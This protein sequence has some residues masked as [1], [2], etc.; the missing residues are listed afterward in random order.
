[1]N[2]IIRDKIEA[3][4]KKAGFFKL[5]NRD[6]WAAGKVPHQRICDLSVEPIW[7]GISTGTERQEAEECGIVAVQDIKSDVLN[8]FNSSDIKKPAER[9]ISPSDHPEGEPPMEPKS[10]TAAVPPDSA[11][12]SHIFICYACQTGISVEQRSTSF[13]E[14]GRA[15]CEKCI[16]AL[17]EK[18]KLKE[19]PEQEKKAGWETKAKGELKKE[20]KK[21]MVKDDPKPPLS[22]KELS[23]KLEAEEQKKE[24][25]KTQFKVGTCEAVAKQYGIPAELANMFF[26]TLNDGLYIKNPGLLHLAAKK[27]YSRIEVTSKYNEKTSEWESESKIYPKVTPEMVSSICQLTPELQKIAWEYMT[28]PTNGTGA[29]SSK[30][31]KMSTMQPFLKEMSQ[32]RAQNRALR[33]YTG[34]GGTSLEELPEAE[35]KYISG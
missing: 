11:G 5:T 7:I 12:E 6:V 4:L 22:D 1:M 23:D 9:E 32:T 10:E 18:E 28:A 31:V 24:L 21:P 16:A 30:S 27:G 14:H 2:T 29:A 20:K 15:L 19:E 34:Y 35:V 3:Y 33:A 8:F 13:K 25:A 26:M 17:P